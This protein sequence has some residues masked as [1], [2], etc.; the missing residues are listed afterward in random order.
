MKKY[1]ICIILNFLIFNIYAQNIDFSQFKI[2]KNDIKGKLVLI[3][4]THSV[5][6]NNLS[7]YLIIKELTKNFTDSDTLN[8]FTERPY[9]YTLMF[10]K[11][12]QNEDTLRKLKWTDFP[13][14]KLPINALL[15]SLVSLKKNIRFI[16]VEFEYDEG[17]R[18]KSYKYF[19]ETLRDEFTKASLPT[20]ELDDYIQKID[21]KSLRNKDIEELKVF[22]KSIPLKTKS[23]AD[24]IF[25]LEAK[26]KHFGYRDKNIYERFKHIIRRNLDV[27]NQYNLL[28]YGGNHINPTRSK[29]LFN[30][31]NKDKESPFLGNTLLIANYYFDCTSNGFYGSKEPSKANGGIYEIKGDEMIMNE[32]KKKDWKSGLFV[33]KNELTLPLQ[34]FDKILYFVIHQE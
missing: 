11:I 25:I 23:I 18:I 7:Y 26:H 22:L 15:D 17:K 13:Q 24:A 20:K 3:N 12:L 16:G 32:L 14:N 31:F 19:F 4:E 2:N 6:T 5:P 30:L 10:N 29:N 34:S 8:I 27:K 28:I 1:T 21:D 33:I 9:S